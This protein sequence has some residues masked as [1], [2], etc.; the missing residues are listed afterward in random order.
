MCVHTTGKQ[1]SM[2]TAIDTVYPTA[3]ASHPSFIS[4]L[5]YSGVVVATPWEA[6][7]NHNDIDASVPVKYATILTLSQLK[8]GVLK[9]ARRKFDIVFAKGGD[10]DT[11]KA[12]VRYPV[13]FI[14]DPVGMSKLGVDEPTIHVAKDN[15]VRFAY[16]LSTLF[17][18]SLFAR[19]NA[20][21]KIGFLNKLLVHYNWLPFLFSM[22]RTPF[23]LRDPKDLQAL[24]E[25]TNIPGNFLAQQRV[26]LH[27]VVFDES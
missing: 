7:F 19:I 15:N 24:L 27:K 17:D 13:D 9:A 18:L 16:S 12:I 14:L 6:E 21:S 20:L 10:I 25:A 2:N 5:G 8:S 23:E 3:L 1:G 22:A 11:N 26:Y 4:D